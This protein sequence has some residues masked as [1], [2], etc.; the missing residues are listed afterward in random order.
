MSITKAFLNSSSNFTTFFNTHLPTLYPDIEGISLDVSS[1]SEWFIKDSSGKKYFAMNVFTYNNE[2][3][4]KA[5]RLYKYADSSGSSSAYIKIGGDNNQAG[6]RLTGIGYTVAYACASGIYF[7]PHYTQGFSAP[8]DVAVLLTKTS[9]GSFAAVAIHNHTD[10]SSG[11]TK[12][13][14]LCN[15]YVVT[16]DDN[17]ADTTVANFKTTFTAKAALQTQLVPFA[18]NPASDGDIVFLP[19]AYYMPQGQHRSLDDGIITFDSDSYV[20]NGYW[21]LKDA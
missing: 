16:M 17:A 15:P 5:L 8:G 13:S 21:A 6:V 12:S 19:K 1:S 9:N 7:K 2:V 18:G 3:Y 20:T 10:G 14:Q 11:N 4:V